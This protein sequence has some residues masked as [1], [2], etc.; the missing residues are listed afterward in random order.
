[1]GIDVP[2][3]I[4]ERLL[5]VDDW[6]TAT[7]QEKTTLEEPIEGGTRLRSLKIAD[8]SVEWLGLSKQGPQPYDVVE[9]S[10][11]GAL[12]IVDSHS[13]IMRFNEENPGLPNERKAKR[14]RIGGIA[15][16]VQTE[17]FYKRKASDGII[18]V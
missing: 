9:T 17:S 13:E 5:N 7:E 3:A 8:L 2:T 18:D 4:K 10:P 12:T 11:P 15:R 14:I 16:G 6:Y 1:L